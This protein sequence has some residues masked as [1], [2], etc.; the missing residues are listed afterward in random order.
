MWIS[1]FVFINTSKLKSL[2][3]MY[4]KIGVVGLGYVGLPLA[5]AFGKYYKTVGYDISKNKIEAYQKHEDPTGEMNVE[6]F[7]KAVHFE[8]TDDATKLTECDFIIIAMPTPVDENNKPDFSYLESASATVGQ[9]MKQDCIVVYE[10]TVYPGATEE[11]CIPVLERASNMVWKRDFNIGY[12][13]ERVSPGKGSKPVTQILKI[14]SGDTKET[15]NKLEHLYKSIIDAGVY[16]APSIKVAEAAKIVENIQ[17]DVN[18]ALMNQLSIIFN[19]LGI[20]TN[21]VIDAASTKWNFADYRPGLVGG[22]CI[23]VDPYYLIDRASSFGQ[24]PGLLIKARQINE[25]MTDWIVEQSLAWF[26]EHVSLKI[27][28]F[29]IT[30]KENCGDMRNSKT[31]DL[32]LRYRSFHHDV[33]I[34]DPVAAWD[35]YYEDKGFHHAELSEIPEV[36][37]IILAVSHDEFISYKDTFKKM[38]KKDG[39]FMD[40]K[41]TFRHSSDPFFKNAFTL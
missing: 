35:P 37:L 19:S 23:G 2:I 4:Q 17:R 11:I 22:H 38:L 26:E 1:F 36:D 41:G 24:D 13:P 29:G 6:Q 25:S 10:S 15:A 27:A 32:V 9:V 14:V 16:V 3:S 21:E 30:F 39:I 20:D 12:S 18:I 31:I 7:Q 40:L 5:L 28:V 34:H 8:A 33:F